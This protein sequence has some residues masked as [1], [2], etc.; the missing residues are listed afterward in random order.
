MSRR[1]RIIIVVVIL[2]LL[3]A[4]LLAWLFLLRGRPV[5]LPFFGGETAT[6]V[7]KPLGGTLD[8]ST[9]AR[10]G[11]QPSGPEASEPETAEPAE[12][13]KPDV[14]AELRRLAAAFAERYGS[15]SNQSD[16]ENI[17]DLRVFMSRSMVEWSEDYVA[18]ARAKQAVSPE[19]YG[20][21][22]RAISAEIEALD[23]TGGM[24]EILVKT[25]RQE[26]LADGS[27]TVYYQ[28]I[29]VDLI[30]ENQQWKVDSATW[31]QRSG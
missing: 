15:F 12:Q 31:K 24:A 27:E 18:D 26:I 4:A 21:I 20:V 13:P 30:T 10:V 29:T 11:G 17:A 3:L 14:G 2:L 22:T 5:D 9:S 1:A 8:L 6:E 23:E 7:S 16:F 25:Q 19:Y 28:D